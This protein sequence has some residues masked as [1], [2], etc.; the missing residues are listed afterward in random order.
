[1]TFTA[2]MKPM[3]CQSCFCIIRDGEQITPFTE[4][5]GTQPRQRAHHT[6]Y[7]A[8]QAALAS[9]SLRYSRIP[10][11]SPDGVRRYVNRDRG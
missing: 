6:N 1:M 4:N 7:T 3:S 10:G 11:A 9:E 2:D 5:Q 8:C